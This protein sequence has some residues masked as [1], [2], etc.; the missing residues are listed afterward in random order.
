MLQLLSRLL[1]GA[2]LLIGAT[3][4][5][6]EPNA[7]ALYKEHCATCHGEDRLGR[8]GPALLPQNLKRL[9]KKRA[10][11]VIAKGRPATQMPAFAETLKQDEIAALAGYIFTPLPEDPVWGETEIEAIRNVA[12]EVDKYIKAPTNHYALFP[13]N[14]LMDDLP[15]Q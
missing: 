3:A 14:V 2:T 5:A 8:Q 10:L 15:R 7:P 13:P 4:S 11:R 12:I 9:R 1:A 6:A